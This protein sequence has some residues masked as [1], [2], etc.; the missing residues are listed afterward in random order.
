M[1]QLVLTIGLSFYVSGVHWP[2]SGVVTKPPSQIK[3]LPKKFVN[4]LKE[5]GCGIPTGAIKENTPKALATI[6]G[7]VKGPFVKEDQV[8]YAAV[9]VKG[10]SS[11]IVIFW[12]GQ[13]KCK[14]P[15]QF[16][17]K[18]KDHI[19]GGRLHKEKFFYFSRDL[20]VEEGHGVVAL[21]ET[22][23]KGIEKHQCRNGQWITKGSYH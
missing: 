4:L 16:I 13:K 18:L 21:L 5:K 20:S 15:K 7:W 8:D 22:N 1:V 10:N 3:G 2:T 11:Q 17:A 14:T 9:C 6:K 19:Y 12:G 23:D